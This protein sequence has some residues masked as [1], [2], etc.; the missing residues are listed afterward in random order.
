[1]K[2]GQQRLHPEKWVQDHG[3]V[4]FRYA[5]ARL[6]NRTAAEEVVQETLLAALKGREQFKGQASERTWLVGIL[7]HKL[8]DQF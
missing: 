8:M 7:K 6:R 2:E 3:D 1:V 5:L 4:L